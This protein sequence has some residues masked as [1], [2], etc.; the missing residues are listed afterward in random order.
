MTSWKPRDR[1]AVEMSDQVDPAARLGRSPI[2]LTS[3]SQAARYTA[4]ADRMTAK[5]NRDQADILDE[6]PG[7]PVNHWSAEAVLGTADDHRPV[8]DGASADPRE[9]G[10]ALGLLGLSPGA[11][12]QE[13]TA[14]F[15]ALAKQHHP[16]RWA[17]AAEPLRRRH[18]E[19]MLRINRA[20]RI[21][22]EA[23]LLT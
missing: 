12:G 10:P 15:R 7:P 9:T 18:A 5:R 16:D 8:D 14:A 19:E 22:R 4:W 6:H 21:L 20:Y 11:D 13:V 17:G 2:D 3:T 1:M 23:A